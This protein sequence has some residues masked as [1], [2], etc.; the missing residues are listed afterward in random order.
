[1][2]QPFL[3]DLPDEFETDRL[4]IRCVKPGDGAKVYEALRESIDSLRQFPAS[5]PWALEEPSLEASEIYCREGF[6]KFIARR[7]FR[8]LVLLRG[9]DTLVGCCGLHRP[10]WKVPTIEVGWWGRTAYL[11]S[12]YVSEAVT[13]LIK[14]AFAQLPVHRVAAFVDDL[15]EKSARVCERAGMTFEGLLRNERVDPD[16]TLR[17]TRVYATI[18]ERVA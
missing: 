3:L 2:I 9:S 14:F 17:H 1:M 6:A 12:G 15:N 16:G 5:L 7:D 11:G 13:G 10:N 18:R 8:F 4:H